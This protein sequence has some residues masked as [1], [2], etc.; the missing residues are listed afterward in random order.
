M[1]QSAVGMSG[2]VAVKNAAGADLHCDENVQNAE[3]CGDR[4]EEVAGDQTF[5]VV[6]Y[7]CGPS[8]VAG[9]AAGPG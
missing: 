8:V 9:C 1:V 7:E 6:P 2:N 4:Y 3:S 5:R